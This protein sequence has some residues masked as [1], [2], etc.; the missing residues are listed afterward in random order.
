MPYD[1][2]PE[3]GAT[4]ETLLAVVSRSQTHCVH[5]SLAGYARLFSWLL[6]RN[7]LSPL[8]TLCTRTEARHFALLAQNF[9]YKFAKLKIRQYGKNEIF[10]HFAKFNARQI[11]PLYGIFLVTWGVKNR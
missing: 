11:F 8:I 2:S 4:P 1:Y 5:E 10:G 3:E 6:E 9:C 7:A